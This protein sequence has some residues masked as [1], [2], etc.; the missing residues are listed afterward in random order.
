MTSYARLLA[1]VPFALVVPLAASA[2]W[3]QWRGPSSA[4]GSPE[5][6]LP[7][8]WSATENIAWKAPLEGFGTSSPIV[9]G[10]LVFV[11]SQVGQ[12]PVAAGD[13]HPQLARDDGELAKREAP[14]GG[15]Y[16]TS[17]AVVDPVIDA[18]SGTLG[19]RLVLPN[20]NGRIPAGIRCRVEFL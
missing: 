17:V 9:S 19:V 2:D 20:R 11:T 8:T 6:P 3:P 5:S 4:G 10:D 18:A 7:V 12:T 15:R 16:E 13:A 1:V 14:I